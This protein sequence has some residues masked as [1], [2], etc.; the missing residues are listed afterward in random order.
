VGC[1]LNLVEG[2]M[3]VRTTRKVRTTLVH[4]AHCSTPTHRCSSCFCS[5]GRWQLGRL[6]C[7]VAGKNHGAAKQRVCTACCNSSC[8][9]LK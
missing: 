7:W 3:T 9:R 4:A 8:S 2:S 6:L 5:V 1:E